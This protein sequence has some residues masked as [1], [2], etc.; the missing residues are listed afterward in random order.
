MK[1]TGQSDLHAVS[2]KRDEDVGLDP[3]LVLMEDRTDREIAL[4]VAERL[5]V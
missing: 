2:Q 5:S 4:E 1:A 3:L